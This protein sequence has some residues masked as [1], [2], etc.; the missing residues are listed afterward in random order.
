MFDKL[1]GI[2]RLN[3]VDDDLDDDYEE[4]GETDEQ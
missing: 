2:L 1:V 3:D 4:A